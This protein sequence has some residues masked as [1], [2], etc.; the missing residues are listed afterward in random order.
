MKI[1]INLENNSY[2]IVL[3]KGALNSVGNYFNLDRKVLI[4]TD[5]GVPAEYSQLVANVSK[6]PVIYKIKSGEDSKSLASFEKIAEVMLQNGFSRKDCVVAV[7]GGVVGDLAGFVAATY[8]RGVDFYNIPTTL[9]S[10]VDSSIGGKVAVNF[11]GVKNILG[12]F[13]QPKMVLIDPL[14]LKTLD[15][16]QLSNGLAE[17]IKMSLT[18]DASLFEIIESGELE[19]NIEQIIEKSLLIKKSVVQQDE[20]EK[21]LRKVLNFG[22]T[23]GHAVEALSFGKLY[24]GECVAIGMLPFCSEAVKARVQKILDKNNL[25]YEL[26]VNSNEIS[27]VISHDKKSDGTLIECV[28]V[29]KVGTFRFE[30]LTKEQILELL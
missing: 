9:L 27:N 24:H 22:H 1:H 23:V 20:K 3:E 25:P 16:R 26:P 11:N 17:A 13:Y 15:K 30:K 14:V 18:S 21:G 19:K 29:D 7:G 10:Q 8:M 28:F 6:H 4:L 5:D 12:V 2:D